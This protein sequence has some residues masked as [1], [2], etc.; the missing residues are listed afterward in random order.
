MN[1]R[2][3]LASLNNIANTLDNSGF[4]RE[5]DTI[6]KVMV[7]LAEEE[8]KLFGYGN[9]PAEKIIEDFVGQARSNELYDPSL[10]RMMNSRLEFNGHE[11]MSE[12]QFKRMIENDNPNRPRDVSQ[13]LMELL[14]AMGY[15]LKTEN[16]YTFA[17]N[18]N[19][20]YFK[21][22]RNPSSEEITNLMRYIEQSINEGAYKKP[23]LTD[24][25]QTPGHEDPLDFHQIKLELYKLGS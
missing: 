11:R 9:E 24:K 25:D 1:K 17:R 19:L 10:L 22:A 3:I 21:D 13:K 4:N 6:T 16:P 2:Q 23:R 5:A 14:V 15:V 12:E 18:T 20:G 7:K 8:T